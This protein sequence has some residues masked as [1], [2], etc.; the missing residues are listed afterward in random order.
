MTNNVCVSVQQSDFDLAE[1]QNILKANNKNIGAIVA[2]T[3]LCRDES[4]RLEALELE[5]Y[6]AMAHSQI[7]AIATSAQERFNLDAVKVIHR[8]G[9]IKPG[10][11]IV[12]VLTAS[13]HRKAAFEAADF[14]MDYM[15]TDA[16]FWKKEHL[17]NNVEGEWV[18]SRT[19]DH[20]AQDRW[21]K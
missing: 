17:K 13:R 21:K 18:V 16:P 9:M 15:K 14:L 8:Y 4:G 1:E 20:Q 5:H 7:L 11:N 19:C 10:E 12:L 6:P 3:G 2:F